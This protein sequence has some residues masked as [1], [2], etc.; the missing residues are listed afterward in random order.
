MDTIDIDANPLHAYE[1]VETTKYYC[2]QASQSKQTPELDI[3]VT[4]ETF[5]KSRGE[6]VST[7]SI[8][9]DIDE[10]TV[11]DLGDYEGTTENEYESEEEEYESVSDEV[12]LIYKTL[13]TT[14]TY[15]TTFFEG[16]RTTI[17]S[18]TEVLT[19]IVSS[20]LLPKATLKSNT[21]NYVGENQ[22]SDNTIRL[23]DHK[24][25]E[26]SQ[27]YSIPDE[28]ASLLIQESKVNTAESSSQMM[29]TLRDD[30]I[31]S[32]TLLTTY[33][34]YTSIFTNN[35]TEVQ[36]R[37]EI[38]TNYIT[39][40][41]S[42][43]ETNFIRNPQ[44]ANLNF[45]K[46]Q[47]SLVEEK[48]DKVVNMAYG[49]SVNSSMLRDS[50]PASFINQNLLDDQVSSESNTEE[51]IPSAT[52]LLQ[53]SFTTF[54]FYTTMYVGNDTSI[55]SR[56][57]TITNVATEALH[58]TKLISVEDYSLPITYFTTFTYWTK[59]AKD[60]EITTLSRGNFIQCYTT[61]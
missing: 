36:S 7:Y 52:F 20:T 23:I 39:D 15:L 53:T 42:N 12:D 18:H 14:Y 22:I 58:P 40:N 6:F 44:T 26:F 57:E 5:T 49:M 9:D 11:Q 51:I 13:Y 60:G 16:S 38:V 27:K 3:I 56:H 25:T 21:L 35:E 34:Y 8:D 41:V 31:Y 32:K 1:I 19:N 28:I 2:I 45:L 61:Q 48:I 4:H 43:N 54:T 30:L 29:T 17:S 59:L 55:I 24:T 47:H 37:T 46:S 33:T 50:S 10:T